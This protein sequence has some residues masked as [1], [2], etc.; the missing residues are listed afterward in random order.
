MF[1]KMNNYDSYLTSNHWK[2][3]RKIMLKEA[4]YQCEKC[5][6]PNN[7]QV[8][9]LN[10]KHLWKETQNDLQVLCRK[11]HMSKPEHGLNHKSEDD[12]GWDW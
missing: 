1:K 12:F 8:H 4:G 11:C 6:S 7:L 10:Y 3:M 9:H 5:K 2:T